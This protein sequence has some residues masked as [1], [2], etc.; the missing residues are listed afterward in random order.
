MRAAVALPRPDYQ[1]TSQLTP[2]LR[3]WPLSLFPLEQFALKNYGSSGATSG[4]S[5][6]LAFTPI[7]G[8]ELANPNQ[9][10][11]DDRMRDGTESYFSEYSGFRSSRAALG[12][13]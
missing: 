6:S 10:T 4:L 3:G 7:Q 1:S 2:C 13:G 9:A 11:Q 8:I 12:K 5:S